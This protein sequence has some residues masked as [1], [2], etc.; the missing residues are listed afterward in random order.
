MIAEHLCLSEGTVR[1]RVTRLLDRAGC[2]NRT[3]L[4]VMW[5]EEKNRKGGMPK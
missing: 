2:M 3:Q 5:V 1:N 4:A